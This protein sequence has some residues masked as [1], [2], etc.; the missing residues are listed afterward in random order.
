MKDAGRRDEVTDVA[1]DDVPAVANG[2]EN[3]W[4]SRTTFI[5]LGSLTA[6]Y[7]LI[8]GGLIWRIAPC[9]NVVV[10]QWAFLRPIDLY[11]QCRD[12]NELGDALA[13]AFAPLAFLW[14]VGAVIIQ[15]LE[16]KEQG[17]ELEATRE[18]MREQARESR[19]TRKHIE[20]QTEFQRKSEKRRDQEQLDEEFDE[21]LASILNILSRTN[22]RPTFTFTIEVDVEGE[23]RLQG[24]Y[25][26]KRHS[27]TVYLLPFEVPNQDHLFAKLADFFELAHEEFGFLP[28]VGDMMD[29]RLNNGRQI[30][31]VLGVFERLAE[32]EDGLSP[33]HKMR[34]QGLGYPSAKYQLDRMW[35]AL[36]QRV[37]EVASQIREV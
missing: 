12:I 34:S 3:R 17:R 7:L 23:E 27:Q 36:T 24:V 28:A 33:A 25:N 14:L 32:I 29:W 5:V 31:Q 8:L 6:L 15:S 18:V 26:K 22:D 35:S 37:P 21:G 1:D 20:Q 9:K 2:I 10:S 11:L 13:G 19:G 16:L 4:S 30:K